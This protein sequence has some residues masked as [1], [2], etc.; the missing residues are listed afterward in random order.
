M[1][2]TE[3]LVVS[4]DGEKKGN[5]QAAFDFALFLAGDDFPQNY[6]AENR[7]TIPVKK[8]VFNSPLYAKGPPKTWLRS[9]SSLRTL[10]AS[11]RHGR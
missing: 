3:P 10:S 9:A 6:I 1:L 8:S 2:H 11:T 7:P 4:K 5:A